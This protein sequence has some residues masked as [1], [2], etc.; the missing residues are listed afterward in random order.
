MQTRTS[1]A[2]AVIAATISMIVAT[3]VLMPG[4]A[5]AQAAQCAGMTVT[6]DMNANGGDGTGTPDAD[7]I[8]GTPG[9]DTIVAGGGDDVVCSGGGR[10]TV[11]GG[12]GADLIYG[13]GGHDVLRGGTGDDTIYGQPGADVIAGQ[14]G[15]DRLLGGIGYDRLDGG[16]GHDFIQGSGGNDLLYGN[17]GNDALYGKAGD[18]EMYGGEGDDELYA[19]GGDDELSGGPGADRLQGGSGGDILYGGAGSD[20][21]YGQADNDHM[22]G[23]TGDDKLYASTGDDIVFGGPGDDILQGGPGG[24]VLDGDEGD[25]ECFQDGSDLIVECE[26]D[27]SS[28]LINAIRTRGVLNCGVAGTTPGMSLPNPAGRMVGLDADMCRAVAAAILGDAEAVSFISLTTAERF[29]ALQTGDVDVLMRN[30][31]YRSSRDADLGVDFGPTTYVDGQQFMARSNDGFSPTSS[32]ADVDGAIV[33]TLAGTTLELRAGQAIGDAGLSVTLQG[34]ETFDQVVVEFI[35]GACDVITADGLAL[36]TRRT[37]Q[38]PSPGDWQIFPP[39]P[40]TVNHLAP[41][42]AEGD[43]AFAATIDSIITAVITGE[44]SGLD[45]D[46]YANVINQVGDYDDIFVRNLGLVGGTRGGTLNGDPS[47][48]GLIG[49]TGPR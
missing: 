35:R 20:L 22:E 4:G 18:D 29:T 32:I 6:I 25:D 17:A 27:S 38:E 16:D 11:D 34:F 26:P 24:D 23:G 39:I 46:A 14:D 5:H 37:W 15:E 47:A 31:A 48:G 43:P 30:T 19:A 49:T 33:C 9:P 3:V 10:D 36:I 2:I 7:V 13:G 21:V 28:P 1:V 42:Y 41:V 45:S 8:L 12:R 40:L 44:T